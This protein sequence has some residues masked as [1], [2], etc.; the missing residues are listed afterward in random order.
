MLL[1]LE[2]EFNNQESSLNQKKENAAQETEKEE[3]TDLPEISETESEKEPF[4]GA[5]DHR[6]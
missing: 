1:L 4:A 3:R 5:P 2:N 6:R